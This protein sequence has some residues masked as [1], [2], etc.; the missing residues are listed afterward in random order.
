MSRNKPYKDLGKELPLAEEIASV[1]ALRCKFRIGGRMRPLFR[2][3]IYS[4]IW[5]VSMG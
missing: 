2:S 1:K 4:V 5:K 3:D